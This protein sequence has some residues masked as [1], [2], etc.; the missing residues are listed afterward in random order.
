M[1]SAMRRYRKTLQVALLVVVAGFVASLF[2]FG[3]KSFDG[4]AGGSDTTV[5]TVN[6]EIG[7]ASCRERVYVL[8]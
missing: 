1:I 2:V 4:G 8:V 5:A 6:G 3:S 7:R